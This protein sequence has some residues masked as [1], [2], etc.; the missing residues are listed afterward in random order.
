M[1]VKKVFLQQPSL[2]II[3]R[4]KENKK[5]QKNHLNLKL[6]PNQKSADHKQKTMHG[7][8]DQ[9]KIKDLLKTHRVEVGYTNLIHLQELFDIITFIRQPWYLVLPS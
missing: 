4:K 7:S 5:I 3:E 2:K 8:Y 9:K 1:L 6:F